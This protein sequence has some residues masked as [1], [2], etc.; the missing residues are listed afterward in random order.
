VCLFFFFFFLFFFFSL[1]FLVNKRP[2]FVPLLVF[3]SSSVLVF[4]VSSPPS[5]PFDLT[6]RLWSAR[7]AGHFRLCTPF[8]FLSPLLSIVCLLF[9]SRVWV[10][11]SGK[12]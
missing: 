6:P 12:G 9:G 3:A 7:L 4:P 10:C 2:G 8:R 5:C 1:C 11:M